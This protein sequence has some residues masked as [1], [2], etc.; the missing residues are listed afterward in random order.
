MLRFPGDPETWLRLAVFELGVLD[1]PEQALET[2]KGA[3]YLDPHGP[4]ARQIFLNARARLR[5][6][7]GSALPRVDG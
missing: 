1:A 4:R 7:T 5:E 2:I 6:K 3:L